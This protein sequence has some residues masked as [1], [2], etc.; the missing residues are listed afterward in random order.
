[1]R[2]PQATGLPHFANSSANFGLTTLDR[3]QSF[4]KP[5][6]GRTSP[7]AAR[8]PGRVRGAPGGRARV[9]R[10]ALYTCQ[11]PPSEVDSVGSSI[12]RRERHDLP[13]SRT[14]L[15]ES[16]PGGLVVIT[17]RGELR[18]ERQYRADEGH[19]WVGSF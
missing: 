15:W 4:C 17:S 3:F 9:R 19:D 6:V 18:L 10:P 14:P 12:S 11:E 2:R 8:P 1:M 16:C 13:A 5:M 7:S